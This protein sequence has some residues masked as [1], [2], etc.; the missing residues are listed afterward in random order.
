MHFKLYRATEFENWTKF[1]NW[2][3]LS[4]QLNSYVHFIMRILI[5]VC[6]YYK[7][8]S[9]LIFSHKISYENR[10][11]TLF[12]TKNILKFIHSNSLP[13]WKNRWSGRIRPAGRF[14]PTAV[15]VY[16][17]II[18]LMNKYLYLNENIYWYNWKVR[19]MSIKEWILLKIFLQIIQIWTKWWWL[20]WLISSHHLLKNWCILFCKFTKEKKLLKLWHTYKNLHHMKIIV[21]YSMG[22]SSWNFYMFS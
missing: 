21:H 4:H 17:F 5:R 11:F 3:R 7:N 6:F 16:N 12:K 9:D 2:T 14:M 8:N 20:T 1:E 15:I 22:S 13:A 10:D 19:T 18:E